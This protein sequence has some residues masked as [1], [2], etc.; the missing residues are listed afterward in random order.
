MYTTSGFHYIY[1]EMQPARMR[2]AVYALPKV[3]EKQL[4][5]PWIQITYREIEDESGD[6]EAQ[7]T[8]IE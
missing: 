8:K 1:K 3:I 7:G 5:P 6:S 2:D 4:N